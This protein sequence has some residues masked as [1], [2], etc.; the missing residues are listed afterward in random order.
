MHNVVKGEIEWDLR[1]GGMLVQKREMGDASSG[2]MVIIKVSHGFYHHGIT[3]PAQSTFRFKDM[4][5]VV[6]LEDSASKE[7]K[8]EEMKRKQSVV[9]SCEE[10]AKV[11]AEIDKLSEK[12]NSLDAIV[13][14]GTKVAVEELLCLTELLMAQLLQLDTIEAV[15]EDKVQRRAEV[16]RVQGLVDTMDEMK[17]RNCNPSSING[18]A[19]I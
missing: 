5:K 3:V 10:V 6:I 18:D 2:P 14:G 11:R 1:P 8:L 4:S 9:I 12:V 16:R 19:G 15:G 13:G 17:A 7:R